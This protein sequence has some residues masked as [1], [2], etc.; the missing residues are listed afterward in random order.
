[1]VNT[2]GEEVG[3]LASSSEGN[4]EKPHLHLDWNQLPYEYKSHTSLSES[5]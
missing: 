4:H 1:M 5:A 3:G 2:A